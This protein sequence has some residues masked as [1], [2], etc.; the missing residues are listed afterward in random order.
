MCGRGG[1]GGGGCVIGGSEG[2][3]GGGGLKW[4]H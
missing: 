2:D 3:C 1:W 4:G